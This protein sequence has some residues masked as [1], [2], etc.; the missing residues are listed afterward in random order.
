MLED[1]YYKLHA[2]ESEHWWYVGARAVY[3]TLLNMVLG[4]HSNNY[5]LIE[6]GSGSGGNLKLIN[7]FG[8]TVGV[9]PSRLAID[10]TPTFPTL[11]LV[12]ARAEALPFAKEIFDGI[13]LLGVIEHLE[14]DEAGLFEAARVCKSKGGLV[15]LTSALPILWSH[16]DD[17]NFHKRRYVKKNLEALLLK[18]GFVPSRLSYQNFF[19]FLPVLIIRL[20]QNR[21]YQTPKYDMGSPPKIINRLLIWLIK[22]EAIL[23]RFISLPIGVDL[24]AVCRKE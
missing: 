20:W 21:R 17:A 12:Q 15:L 4:A 7:S 3:H 1:S 16:H 6:I 19:T 23:I 14:D 9:E 10:M 2:L 18:S 24:V 13:N 11:G 5:R 22:I 8:P